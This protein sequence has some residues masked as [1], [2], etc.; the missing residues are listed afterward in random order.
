MG[1]RNAQLV[2]KTQYGLVFANPNGLFLYNG[3]NIV[4]LSENLISDSDWS[5]HITTDS[6]IIY[7]EQESQVYV[8]KQMDGDGQAYMCDLKKNVFTRIQDFTPDG[9]DGITNSVD[10]DQNVYVGYDAGSQIDVHKLVRTSTKQTGGKLYF[11]DLDFG[12]PSAIKKIYAVYVTYKSDEALTGLFHIRRDGSNID[13]DGTIPISSGWNTVKIAPSSPIT[14]TKAQ[15][16]LDL[17]TADPNVYINDV[18]IEY[19]IIKKKAS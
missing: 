19:R 18:S 6:C 4:N 2:K 10:T 8:I 3:N 13:L 17:D 16:R 9:N 7:D 12:D 15:F 1:I 11:K 5:S 14:C